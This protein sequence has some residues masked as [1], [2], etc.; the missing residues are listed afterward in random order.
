MFG[1]EILFGFWFFGIVTPFEP[2]PAFLG[3]FCSDGYEGPRPSPS[4]ISTPPASPPPP[5]LPHSP[6]PNNKVIVTVGI[7]VLVLLSAHIKR[8]SGIFCAFFS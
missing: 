2:S 7:F 3:G 8:F 5:R 1:F 6:P 4:P